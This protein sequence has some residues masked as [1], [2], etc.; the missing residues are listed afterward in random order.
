MRQ[1]LK[2][3]LSPRGEILAD[4]RSNTLIIRDIP[5]VL[6]T[7]DRL[8][9]QLDRRSPQ[10]QIEARVVVAT[11]AFARDLGTQFG[12]AVAGST[13]STQNVI[14]GAPGVGTSPIVRNVLPPPPL[15]A[16]S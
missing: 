2:Q 12:F 8:I 11:R 7:I 5:S 4:T 1:I 9:R 14:G 10:A 3:F 6:P 13:G 15:E 16:I